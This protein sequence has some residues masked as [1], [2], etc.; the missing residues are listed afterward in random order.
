MA[1]T[2]FHNLADLFDENKQRRH[3]S[4]KIMVV[5]MQLSEMWS[6]TQLANLFPVAIM[7]WLW[8]SVSILFARKFLIKLQFYNV[9]TLVKILVE[10]S[11]IQ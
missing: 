5:V 3:D 8:P 6:A 4:F 9:R 2:R 11:I 7:Q 10:T 1:V